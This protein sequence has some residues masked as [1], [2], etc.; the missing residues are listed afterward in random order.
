MIAPTHLIA[1]VSSRAGHKYVHKL[2]TRS[3]SSTAGLLLMR[4]HAQIIICSGGHICM[5]FHVPTGHSRFTADAPGCFASHQDLLLR[6]SLAVITLHLTFQNHIHDNWSDAHLCQSDA[7][8][9]QRI[10]IYRR[11]RIQ[12]M[13]ISMV[14][15]GVLVAQ[16]G[17]RPAG[18]SA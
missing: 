6:C 1:L 16:I 17:G 8:L 5:H 2:Q 12:C 18:V 9:C 15:G 10:Y 13:W 14:G 11:I 3:R 4:T 7:Y